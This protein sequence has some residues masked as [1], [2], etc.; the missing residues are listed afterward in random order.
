M[1]NRRLGGADHHLASGGVGSSPTGSAFPK[2]DCKVTLRRMLRDRDRKLKDYDKGNVTQMV[3]F[4]GQNATYEL[5]SKCLLDL[6]DQE[7]KLI[8]LKLKRLGKPSNA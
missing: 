8:R 1:T 7:R 4:H 5:S 6:V 2:T 3:Y